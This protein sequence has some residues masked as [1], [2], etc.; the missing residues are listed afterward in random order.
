MK[1]FGCFIALLVV[2]CNRNDASHLRLTRIAPVATERSV[3]VDGTTRATTPPSADQ[4]TALQAPDG[5]IVVLEGS[6]LRRIS[7]DGRL[8]SAVAV[9][10]ARSQIAILPDNSVVVSRIGKAPKIFNGTRL[11]EDLAFTRNAPDAI[12][13]LGARSHL[14]IGE[15]AGTPDATVLL[16][17][18]VEGEADPTQPGFHTS[19]VGV[20]KLRRDGT[21]EHRFGRNGFAELPPLRF[22][23]G[24]ST[25][26]WIGIAVSPRGAITCAYYDDRTYMIRW[27]TDGQIDPRFGANGRIQLD[28]FPKQIAFDREERLILASEDPSQ[29]TLA[30]RRLRTDGSRDLS[31]GV[32]GI[33]RL[34]LR[35]ARNRGLADNRSD[36]SVSLTRAD[37]DSAGRIILGG[38]VSHFATPCAAAARLLPNGAIDETYGPEGFRLSCVGGNS[39]A[40]AV[41]AGTADDTFVIS[42]N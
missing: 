2:A 8:L 12:R 19:H 22:G 29:S 26:T 6:V 39:T 33:A 18:E 41:A 28:D 20:A 42:R 15:T 35:D 3:V 14:S 32:N 7:R 31:F 23:G 11:Q 16:L 24:V 34:H 36:Y 37:I 5:T 38:D 30:V 40:I 25:P 10:K 1:S 9:K 13:E 17:L 27:T 21:I 4:I